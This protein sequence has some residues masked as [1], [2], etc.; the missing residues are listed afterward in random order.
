M[1]VSMTERNLHQVEVLTL[2]GPIGQADPWKLL[3]EHGQIRLRPHQFSDAR[4]E[5]Q[6]LLLSDLGY[7]A[8]PYNESSATGDRARSRSSGPVIL[9]LPRTLTSM[10]QQLFVDAMS[11]RELADQRSIGDNWIPTWT[12]F[13][14]LT[15]DEAAP[16]SEQFTRGI[17]TFFEQLPVNE[18]RR[19]VFGTAVD[20]RINVAATV[21]EPSPL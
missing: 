7:V 10:M 2:D 4:S 1:S 15:A 3:V 6:V 9:L 11:T 5:L 12:C 8:G 21:N 17:G 18:G 14:N 16:N 13:V 20:D 19:Y